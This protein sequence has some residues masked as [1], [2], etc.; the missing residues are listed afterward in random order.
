[1]PKITYGAR[2]VI[3]HVNTG[4]HLHS[5]PFNYTHPGS[6]GLQQVTAY[7]GTDNN[8]IWIAVSYALRP[9]GQNLKLKHE[10]TGGF[11]HSQAGIRAPVTSTQQ[12]VACQ[13]IGDKTCE[14][15]LDIVGG[16]P[17]DL[18][19]TDQPF[20]LVHALSGNALHSHPLALPAWGFGQQEVTAY[21]GGDSNDYW[22]AT[23]TT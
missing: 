11:L 1:M 4:A 14:W 9:N 20:R 7:G 17:G 5:H 22:T 12:E 3:T 15:R 13:V 6:S 2:L 10:L 8:N 23:I 18:W 21:G 16:Q 19:I